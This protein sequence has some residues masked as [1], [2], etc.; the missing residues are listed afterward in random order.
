M[1][2]RNV[3]VDALWQAL[4]PGFYK[5]SPLRALR[6]SHTSWTQASS[7]RLSTHHRLHEAQ[8]RK[9]Q[10]RQR[11]EQAG[12]AY[13][14]KK[15]RA[16]FLTTRNRNIDPPARTKTS[17][18]ATRLQELATR[19]IPAPL[20]WGRELLFGKG[21]EKPVDAKTETPSGQEKARPQEA[22]NGP[23]QSPL[24]PRPP[25]LEHHKEPPVFLDIGRQEAAASALRIEHVS[26]PE[27]IVA[28]ALQGS[29]DAAE[30]NR[31]MTTEKKPV[32]PEPFET[33]GPPVITELQSVPAKRAKATIQRAARPMQ[34]SR[35]KIYEDLGKASGT[36]D[37]VQ[38]H[39]LLR[40]LTQDYGDEPSQRHYQAMLLANVDPCHG[41]AAEL[42]IILQQMESEGHTLDSAAYHAIIKVLAIHPDYLLRRQVLE[43]VRS[44]WFALSDEGW[45]DVIVGLLREKQVEVAL[46]TL[47]SVQQEGIRI[48]PWLY[49]LLIFNLCDAGEHDEALAILEMRAEHGK[50]L[51]SGSIWH[52]ILDT[53]SSAFHYPAT[54]YVWRN[55]VETTSFNPSSGLCLNVL[56]TAARH[57]DFRLA[58]DVVR[59]LEDRKQKLQLY[60]YE[61]LIES[62]LPTD[63][64]SAF[65]VLTFMALSKIWPG[66]SSTRAIFLHLR[67]SH[68]L[69]L[70][71]LEILRELHEQQRPIPVE[72]VNVVIES[73]LYNRLFNQ[74][75]DL[76]KTIH[77]LCP[78]GANLTTFNILFRGCRSR[79]DTAMSLA[80]DMVTMKISP[81]ALTYD[82][83]I[84]VC[85]EASSTKED[86]SDA[87]RY[88]EEM[89]VS[90]WWPRQGTTMALA[91]RA[92][93]LE[94]DRIWQLQ[95]RPDFEGGI[96][97]ATL[98]R[99]AYADGDRND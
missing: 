72:A 80:T 17:P 81:N 62:C 84:L 8:I 77:T 68:E 43:E 46:D 98:M 12:R 61:A 32:D 24:K 59:V 65:V 30:D 93:S 74:A 94:D 69:P 50:Q 38:I 5:T 89:Q 22:S 66:Q 70:E 9:V 57:A 33:A 56:N 79:K 76:Y 3:D 92:C 73:L 58:T 55:R 29:Q 83:L 54:V 42:A 86:L 96:D 71:S 16:F 85:I 31:V 6:T 51:I 44:R 36:G 67:Q 26:N 27:E 45:Q 11:G 41:S 4:C 47:Q 64:P 40:S 7:R 23:I 95:R 18:R 88:L 1:P 97:E 53:A 21:A 60:H 35:D 25:D 28:K 15:A 82:R 48:Q 2:L 10:N 13:R 52:H 91:K 39:E 20:Q 63:L 99:M 90:G 37:Y 87:W 49:D 34:L 14:F 19:W 75:L 78:S